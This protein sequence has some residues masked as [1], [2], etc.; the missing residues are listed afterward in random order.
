MSPYR[1]VTPVP[2]SYALTT[3]SVCV[4]WLGLLHAYKSFG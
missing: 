1:L 2:P 4:Y 3:P